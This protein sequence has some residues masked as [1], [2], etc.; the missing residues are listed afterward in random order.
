MSSAFTPSVVGAFSA[1]AISGD[2]TGT[3]VP[4]GYIGEKLSIALAF[5]ST[6]AVTSNVA[7]NVISATP[8][9]ALTPG[10][11]LLSGIIGYDASTAVF[12]SLEASISKTSATLSPNASLGSVNSSG[13]VRAR[14]AMSG[15][16]N[17][18]TSSGNPTVTLPPTY[19]LITTTTN[20]Y[21]VQNIILS[22]G[23]A[24]CAGS[25]TAIRIA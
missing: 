2:T 10:V 19:A 17:I 18:H 15:G 20:Y 25:L 9:V 23:T 22:S 1:R 3:A 4:A 24:T 6:A 8:F 12:T 13:E 7:S 11:W 16:A 5:T 21:L 14:V